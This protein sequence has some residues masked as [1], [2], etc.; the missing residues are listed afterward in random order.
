MADTPPNTPPV[1]PGA[2]APPAP[3]ASGN[4]PAPPSPPLAPASGG[5][6]RTPISDSK[7]REHAE[8]FPSIDD[9]VRGNLD[10]RQKLSAAIVKPGKDAKPEEIA[11]FRK[12]LDAP[13]SPDGYQFV[14][15][16]H[17]D[18]ETFK[19]EGTQALVKSFADFLHKETTVSKTDAAKLFDWYGKFEAFTL[20]SQ[21]EA[22]ERFA[23]ETLAALQKK[24]PGEEFTKNRAHAER[25]LMAMA[26]QSG[27]EVDELRNI[28]TKA[29]R[30]V[31]DDPNFVQ[32]FA[33]IGR[34]MGE[35]STFGR[36]MTD[37]DRQTAEARAKEIHGKMDEALA[38]NDHEGANKLDQELQDLHRKMGGVKPIVG[39]MGRAA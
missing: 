23:N 35:D 20:K 2:G 22:D 31:F 30:F 21:K 13:E 7:L 8:R 36:V 39:A 28:E 1:A 27:V 32:V 37:S 5:D 24:W 38:R 19:S 17:I 14:R 33:A 26:Q 9:L 18:E 16:E 11:A 29:G 12:A 3:P 10:Q 15:P 34:E 25:A 4:P 6:W